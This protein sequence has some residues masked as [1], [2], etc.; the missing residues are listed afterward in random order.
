V[1]VIKKRMRAL[2]LVVGLTI[3]GTAIVVGHSS[4]AAMLAHGGTSYIQSDSSC[5][6]RYLWGQITNDCATTKIWC[7]YPMITNGGTHTVSANGDNLTTCYADALY[8][9]DNAYAN[10]T[11]PV[12]LSSNGGNNVTIG[13]V[14]VPAYGSIQVCCDMEA[15]ATLNSVNF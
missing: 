14:N 13:N 15:G 2:V 9:A 1:D 6:D 8:A 7:F 12:R 3:M 5:F 4:K 10:G 11:N